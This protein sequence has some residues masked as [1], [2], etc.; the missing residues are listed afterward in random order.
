MY[1]HKAISVLRDAYCIGREAIK[2]I[3]KTN[4]MIC[5]YQ[6]YLSDIQDRQRCFLDLKWNIY[7][8]GNYAKFYLKT[9]QKRQNRTG[10]SS[11]E[12]KQGRWQFFFA[13]VLRDSTI[14]LYLYNLL[15][16]TVVSQFKLSGNI[17]FLCL[18]KTK[19]MHSLTPHRPDLRQAGIAGEGL[20][21]SSGG[22]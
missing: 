21:C 18:N 17:D 20:L 16:L 19:A 3:R 13:S 12:P 1:F 2:D 15:Q 5:K 7:H 6:S 8:Y 14:F 22:G 4:G 11:R 9:N 10:A